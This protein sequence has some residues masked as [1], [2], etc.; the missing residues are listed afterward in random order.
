MHYPVSINPCSDPLERG[1]AILAWARV[2]EGIAETLASSKTRG[3]GIKIVLA[4]DKHIDDAASHE[5]HSVQLD[6]TLAEVETWLTKE[7]QLSITATMAQ[8][9]VPKIRKSLASVQASAGI[10]FLEQK[11]DGIAKV[12]SFLELATDM[13]FDAQDT[14]FDKDLY[15]LLTTIKDCQSNLVS[16]R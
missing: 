4:V 5:S 11:A 12:E 14:A 15:R 13:A 7:G 2:L 10:A 6:D 3:S 16:R 9:V 8:S 1:Q